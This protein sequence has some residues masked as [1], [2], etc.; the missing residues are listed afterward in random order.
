MGRVRR[1]SA[2][3]PRAGLLE[4]ECVRV[5]QEASGDLTS[6]NI[7]WGDKH[8]EKNT[9]EVTDTKSRPDRHWINGTNIRSP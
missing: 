8:L 6:E 1:G 5:F 7:V 3:R 2:D 9:K 4:R